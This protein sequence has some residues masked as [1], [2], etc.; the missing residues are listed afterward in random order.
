MNPVDVKNLALAHKSE[1]RTYT[2][3]SKLLQI[4]KNSAINLCSYKHKMF[5]KKRGLKFTVSKANKLNIKRTIGT[6]KE[7]NRKRN[8][9]K[10][11][12]ECS[13]DVSVR[14]TQRHMK[15]VGFTYRRIPSKIILSQKHK[16]RRVMV[17]N[18]WITENHVLEKTTFSDKKRFSLDGSDDWRAYTLKNNT[19]TR[20][21]RQCS[22]GSSMAWLMTLPSGLLSFKVISEK[23]NSDTYIQMLIN[24]VV[25]ILKLNFE[26]NFWLQEDNS[27]VHKSA[28][29]KEFKRKT[30][31]NILPWS[32]ISSDLNIVED[33]WKI[34]SDQVYDGLQF[35][36]TRE[37]C[38]KV[39]NVIDTINQSQS[40]K[41][42]NLYTSI[43][44]RLCT[45]LF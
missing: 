36:S 3:I 41:I 2:E 25:P 34:I 37:L 43:R 21:R 16:E 39:K 1:G 7:T 42:L 12:I 18:D 28:K 6:L 31:I 24:S 11:K 35:V 19:N 30:S 17:I 23:F 9:K 5:P 32:A 20:Q 14:T 45:V 29:V 10:L 15:A 22:G 44:G 8:L 13:L 40:Q 33:V 4:S 27:P 26:E 38:A